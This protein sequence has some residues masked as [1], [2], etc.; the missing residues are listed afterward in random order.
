M[1]PFRGI[2]QFSVRKWIPVCH[3]GT[4]K[5]NLEADLEK[6]Q[7]WITIAHNGKAYPVRVLKVK[8]SSGEVETLVTSLNQRQ[9][10]LRKAGALYFERWK[11]GT[12]YDLIKSKL[13]LENFSGKTGVSVLQ[14]FY[15]TIYLAN[16]AAFAA[17]EADD[18]I[19]NADRGEN[20]KYCRQANRN[21]TISK[22]RDIFLCLIMEP[23]ADL[24]NAMLEKMVT[25]I[26]RYPVPVVP[27]RSPIR[28]SP[29][30]KRFYMAKKSVV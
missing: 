3:A 14:D 18:R 20:L 22:L 16:I 23:N 4:E 17:R 10:P 24:R 25:S 30:K 5:W 27:G 28:K 15:A 6:T 7:D 19:S 8:L 12:A 21:R 9:L 11:V 13:Q 26:A 29:R 2:Y 1:V